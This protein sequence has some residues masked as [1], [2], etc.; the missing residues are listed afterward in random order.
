MEQQRNP[1]RVDGMNTQYGM[2][3]SHQWNV[4]ECYENIRSIHTH[5]WQGNGGDVHDEASI[6]A[7]GRRVKEN[8]I[9]FEKKG[10]GYRLQF[11]VFISMTNV[12][13]YQEY[14]SNDGCYAL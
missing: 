10:I 13:N 2:Y 3:R 11:L 5:S 4:I 8:S 1:S 12:K 6:N 9:N 7:M 14:Y